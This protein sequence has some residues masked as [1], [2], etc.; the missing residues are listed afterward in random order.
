M[1][2][3]MYNVYNV[4][5]IKNTE[6]IKRGEGTAI[7]FC[8]LATGHKVKQFRNF[9]KDGLNKNSLIRFFVDSWV[10]ERCRTKLSSKVMYVTCGSRCLRLTK[11]DVEEVEDLASDQ[12]EVG[13]YFMQPMQPDITMNH[14]SLYVRIQM[15]L[16]CAW[17]IHI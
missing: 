3:L 5:S 16:S 7:Q 12:E 11:E 15:S 13:S 9:L 8:N 2:S 10:E 1:L 14:W 6:R 17:Q 4:Q